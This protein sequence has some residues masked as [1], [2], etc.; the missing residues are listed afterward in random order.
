MLG[1]FVKKTF[2]GMK[3]PVDVLP[4]ITLV[5]GASVGGAYMAMRKLATDP[6]L[7]RQMSPNASR[8]DLLPSIP[9]VL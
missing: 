2:Q 7:R 6:H 1:E 8:N 4:L 3:P 5:T 9:T